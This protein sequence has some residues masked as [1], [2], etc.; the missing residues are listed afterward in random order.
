MTTRMRIKAGYGRASVLDA[1]MKVRCPSC[2]A[3]C[4]HAGRSVLKGALR[5][6][7]CGHALEL[8]EHVRRSLWFEHA[9]AYGARSQTG[10][11]ELMERRPSQ[12]AVLSAVP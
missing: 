9:R 7:A 10:P 4:E 8:T 5:C 11:V 6:P 1:M 12:R 3:T 2:A